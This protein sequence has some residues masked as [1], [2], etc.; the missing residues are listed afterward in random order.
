MLRLGWNRL[1]PKGGQALAEG[2]RF[3]SS[4]LTELSLQQSGI[5]DVGA[6]HIA[7]VKQQAMC[8]GAGSTRN[9]RPAISS[10]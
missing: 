6:S 4:G 8:C 2:L 10:T 5:T 1:G 3:C 9:G 7:K